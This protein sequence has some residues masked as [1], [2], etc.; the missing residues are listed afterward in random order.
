MQVQK[1]ALALLVLIA[2]TT[3]SIVVSIEHGP[4]GFLDV[5]L[6]GGWN[7][8]VFLDLGLMLLGFSTLAVPDAK[9]HGIPF[10][11]Y[12]IATSLLGSIGMLSYFVH[13]QMRALRGPIT[14]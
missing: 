12:F 3:Y 10:L 8:Q 5:L 9:R 6:G 7:T 13:R 4:L 2:F 1:L 11:P 14:A